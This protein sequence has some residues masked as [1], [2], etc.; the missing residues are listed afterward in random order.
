M[1][2]GVDSKR[3]IL[4]A[5]S[6]SAWPIVGAIP[7]IARRGVLAVY[8]DA[9][10]R[11][12]DV[13]RVPLGHRRGVVVVHPDA[14]AEVLVTRREN[15]VKGDTYKHL[16]VLTGDSLLT[17]EGERWRERRRLAQPAFHKENVRALVSGFAQVTR[18]WLSTLRARSARGCV[19]EAHQEMMR[20]TL[21][22]VG[23]TLL[24]RRL[25]QDAG[26]SAHALG[27]A[28]EV[29]GRRGDLPVSVPRWLPTPGNRRLT[30]ALTLLDGLVFS[31]IDA[32][33]Q[34]AGT[35]LLSLLVGARDVDS[36]QPL[37]DRELRDEVLTLVLAGHET[38]ALLMTWGFSLLHGQ[39]AIVARMR[40]EV[41][42]VLAGREPSAD[43]LPRLVYL[44]QVIEEILRLRPPAW[45]LGRDVVA[46]GTLAG[47][48][49]R[50]GD[51]VMPLPYL[52]HRHPD[53][54]EDPERFD[55]ERFR[56]ERVKAR[57][58]WA[59]YPFSA[60]PR[61]CIGNFFTLA[62]AQVIFA[63]LLQ[64][65]DF[66]LTSS[67]PIPL[68]PRMTLRPGAP[69]MVRLRWRED[70]GSRDAGRFEASPGLGAKS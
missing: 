51:L 3:A 2:V 38:T 50:A 13:F 37:S 64:R 63:L 27:E 53:F 8:A 60:G 52:T 66:E 33:R 47:F 15:Y 68:L 12:G 62:E 16:R 55:P 32:A 59:Y 5:P 40:S 35:S 34:R 21:D 36:G 22:V 10:Q 31:L 28:L 54:W 6:L 49:V 14:V 4:E 65:A 26:M 57:P 70:L 41:D 18:D 45:V 7:E 1:N 58:N 23:E 9:W 39:D 11:H 69:V 61:T 44:K 30:R 25:G 43:D 67:D 42:E 20:L 46:D 56:P 48:R 29:L 17:L 24:G 19:F